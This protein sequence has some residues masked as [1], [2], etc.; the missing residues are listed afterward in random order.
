ML[1]C[2][3]GRVFKKG[4]YNVSLKGRGNVSLPE[5]EGFYYWMAICGY[6]LKYIYVS[7]FINLF[8]SGDGLQ[9]TK[10]SWI[11]DDDVHFRN[12]TYR[13]VLRAMSQCLHGLPGKMAGNLICVYVDLCLWCLSNKGQMK[14]I[15]SVMPLAPSFTGAKFAKFKYQPCHI[16][17]IFCH[18][19]MQ[20]WRHCNNQSLCPRKLKNENACTFTSNVWILLENNKNGQALIAV[21]VCVCVR[22]CVCVSVCVCRCVYL[23]KCV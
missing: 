11:N 15:F 21:C 4:R 13:R 2:L 22:A 9:I 19:R 5:R 12:S 7:T 3:K 6:Y 1:G 10:S 23:C 17:K 8:V 18:I 20:C 16:K 14:I